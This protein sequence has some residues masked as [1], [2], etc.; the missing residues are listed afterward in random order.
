MLAALL[1]LELAL[2]VLC[3]RSLLAST[4]SHL[5]A[6]LFP[7]RNTRMEV[8]SFYCNYSHGHKGPFLHLIALVFC[9]PLV[10]CGYAQGANPRELGLL[11]NPL[12][13]L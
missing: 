5:K 3:R 1:L 8:E 13:P 10:N 12:S 9:A 6:S 7:P 2:L 11:R 4:M